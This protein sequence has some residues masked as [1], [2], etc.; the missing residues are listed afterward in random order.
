[1]SKL[2]DLLTVKRAALTGLAALAV[3]ALP[4][5]TAY[6]APKVS[7]QRTS[8]VI[9]LYV[10][11][12]AINVRSGPNT[13][14]AVAEIYQP[15]RAVNVYERRG[16]WVRISGPNAK[17]RWIKASLLTA[18]RPTKTVT[19][20]SKR[21]TTPTVQI[22]KSQVTKTVQIVNQRDNGKDGNRR[23]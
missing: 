7:T 10:G 2:T 1:M 6:A 11:E 22:K 20:V 8:A 12:T 5:S 16:D 13:R 15:G 4:M 14:Q 17:A 23:G 21:R 9:T 18:K 19:F 3:T